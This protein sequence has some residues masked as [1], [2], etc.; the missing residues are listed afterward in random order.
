M[1]LPGP[2]S[3]IVISGNQALYQ[4]ELGYQWRDYSNLIIGLVIVICKVYQKPEM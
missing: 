3:S 4:P 1:H 2:P